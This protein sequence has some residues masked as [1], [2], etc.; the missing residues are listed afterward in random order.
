MRNC[1]WKNCVRA[2]KEFCLVSLIN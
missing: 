1:E 2:F